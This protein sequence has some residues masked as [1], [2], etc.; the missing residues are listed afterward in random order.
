MIYY[1]LMK[2]LTTYITEKLSIDNI[3]VKAVNKEYND[4]VKLFKNHYEWDLVN[5]EVEKIGSLFKS[6]FTGNKRKI[7]TSY[8]IDTVPLIKV[9]LN[10]KDEVLFIMDPYDSCILTLDPINKMVYRGFK[11]SDSI[12]IHLSDIID[13]AEEIKKNIEAFAEY[14]NR[15]N[16][17]TIPKDWKFKQ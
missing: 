1:L 13:N 10:D 5:K 7:L 17:M 16:G 14:N 9:Y 6:V 4:I 15:W 11:M 2:E 12:L 8:R 3:N